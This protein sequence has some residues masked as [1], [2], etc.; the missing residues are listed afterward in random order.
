MVL[1]PLMEKLI[2]RS[3]M[4]DQILTADDEKE[5]RDQG[6]D[7][8][9]FVVAPTQE[10]SKP[11][12]YTGISDT[13]LNRLKARAGGYIGGGTAAGLASRILAPY[14]LGPEAGIPANIA[15]IGAQALAAYGGSRAGEIGQEKLEGQELA[16]ELEQK[17]AASAQANPTTALLTDIGAGG[18]AG[19]GKL[20]L[21]NPVLA[22]KQLLGKA[23]EGGADALRKVAANAIINPAVNTGVQ[24][25][26]TGQLPSTKDILSQ[27][28]GGAFFSEPSRYGKILYGG[29][30]SATEDNI[31]IDPGRDMVSTENAPPTQ[32]KLTSPYNSIDGEGRPSIDDKS[33]ADLFLSKLNIKPDTTGMNSIEA[34][35]AMSK[36]RNNNR[37][38]IDTKRQMLHDNWVKG[39]QTQAPE[40]V[41]KQPESPVGPVRPTIGDEELQS[42]V[43]TSF[44]EPRMNQGGE[45]VVPSP[46]RTLAKSLFEAQDPNQN[47]GKESQTSGKE[48]PS[49]VQRQ[50]FEDAAREQAKSEL[51]EQKAKEVTGE[52][53]KKTPQELQHEADIEKASTTEI[54]K[55]LTENQARVI[56]PKTLLGNNLNKTPGIDE[57]LQS[58][59]VKD[60]GQLYGGVQGLT[61]AMW[62]GSI[63]AVRLGVKGGKALVDAIN[64]GIDWIKKNH[65]G[66]KFDENA[67]SHA[68]K[69]ELLKKNSLDEVKT[70][71]GTSIFLNAADAARTIQHPL[72][73]E[74]ANKSKLALNMTDQLLGSS[75]NKFSSLYHDL[76]G[77]LEPKELKALN[78]LD[79]G[80]KVT[81]TRKVAALWKLKQQI[82]AEQEQRRL[83]IGRPDD[84]RKIN[85][86][87]P[88]E[89]WQAQWRKD[90][91]KDAYFKH[92]QSNPDLAELIKNSPNILSKGDQDKVEAVT[93]QFKPQHTNLLEE[94]E[95]KF[96]SAASSAL[97]SSFGLTGH[98]GATNMLGHFIDVYES[99]VQ[100]ARLVSKMI[101]NVG[102]GIERA[103]AGNAWHYSTRSVGNIF[104]RTS[105]T[106]DK[107]AA[108]GETLRKFTG[109]ELVEKFTTGAMQIGFEDNLVHKV[110]LAN[111]GDRTA[112]M[113]IKNLDPEFKTGKTY[114]PQ[115]IQQL[116]STASRY[117]I[118]TKDAR[119][120]PA[121]MLSDSE[122]SG[123]FKLAHWSIAQ[124]NRFFKNIYTP[125]LNGDPAPFLKGALGSVVTGYMIKKMREELQGK[126]GAIP[127]IQEIA[128]G[129]GDT[130]TKLKLYGYNA[131]AAMQYAGF[132]GVVSQMA[133]WLPNAMYGDK[134]QGAIFPLD[135][136]VS[137]VG[138]NLKDALFATFNDRLAK[139]PDI[140]KEFMQ[141]VLIR[142]VQM[143]R[144]AINQGI[145]KGIITGTLAQRKELT[146]KLEQLERFQK[147]SGNPFATPSGIGENPY[148]NL[149]QKQFKREQDIPKA[150][151]ML[152]PIIQGI[153]QNYSDK[154]D[155]MM[156]KLKAL[157]EN[158]Y[159][160]FPSLENEPIQ[161]R[162]YMDWLTRVKGPQ[163]AQ[164]ELMEYTKHKAINEAKASV[165][166]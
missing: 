125:L 84:S 113:Y 154:P 23:P 27:M 165:V 55:P 124:T 39:T 103:K 129:S 10:E 50:S 42:K 44:D 155:I 153:V 163:A 62:N 111:N 128:A 36:Y 166:P 60:T 66:T 52:A 91:F 79:E 51:F 112:A 37:L 45:E 77:S 126:K 116:A 108:F 147:I 141:R 71:P 38:D 94:G 118:G 58:L 63:D 149:E 46:E 61:T 152:P 22:L 151:G 53:Q 70:L 16:K 88:I 143:A 76:G 32:D 136:I 96:S 4:P 80:N 24:T 19:G 83:N 67:Y 133:M 5:L 89:R 59:K 107:V 21:R 122:T 134:P 160:T 104:D 75:V 57:W 97:V 105:T 86:P 139:W 132:G 161:F 18:L 131:L 162:N 73:N 115:E 117:I 64:D 11:S 3:N 92:I 81:S 98:A 65:P 31:P 138:T 13:I 100:M 54:P 93:E 20:N 49:P 40:I 82:D 146:D 2:Q 114:S 78:D 120:M 29:G 87:N 127:S 56:N 14:L 33:I 135:E 72:A 145:D 41:E 95:K 34:A 144:M 7:P 101:S 8:K 110:H 159:A 43:A 123:F 17:D 130:D 69:N 158:P 68:V 121:F 157:K 156:A 150:M 148:M 25:A 102:E 106:A 109:R 28:A 30:D 9:D 6:I 137:D 74:L 142:N 47:I 35:Q 99:P 85:E 90:I 15:M 26:L 48:T 119:T 12:S 1:L 140:I 164:Q